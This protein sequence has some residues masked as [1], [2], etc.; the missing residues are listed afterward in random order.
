MSDQAMSNQDSYCQ[1]AI[2]ELSRKHSEKAMVQHIMEIDE[3][4]VSDKNDESF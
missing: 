2:E 1:T 4:H 3:N